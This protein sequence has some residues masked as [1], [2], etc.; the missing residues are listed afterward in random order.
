MT[1]RATDIDRGSR[2]LAQGTLYRQV[3]TTEEG[4]VVNYRFTFRSPDW[5][6]LEQFRFEYDKGAGEDSHL[7]MRWP[8]RWIKEEDA[9]ELVPVLLEEFHAV[10]D[11][12]S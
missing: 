12:V 11:V 3:V 6:G 8:T 1:G 7:H 5:S 10:Q 4:T 2:E 9:A